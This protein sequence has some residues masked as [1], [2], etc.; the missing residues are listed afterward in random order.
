[1]F[2]LLR[3]CW[4]DDTGAV[5]SVEILLTL[6]ILIFGMIPGF[7]A[8]RNSMNSALT[9]V[10]NLLVAIIP[11]FTFSGFAITGTDQNNNPVTILQIGG[12]QF[13]PNRTYLT[14]DQIAPEII[15]P[16]ETIS[17]AP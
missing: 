14:A 13:T 1:M 3:R 4:N 7:V 5:V 17:P 11:S 12:V 10:A 8:L 16:G 6:S 2:T 15:P 9:S